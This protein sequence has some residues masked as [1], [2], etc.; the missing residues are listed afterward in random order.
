MHQSLLSQI[1]EFLAETGM[2]AYRFGIRA[3][4]NGRLVERLKD[5]RRIWPD[6]EAKVRSFIR[7]ERAKRA[8]AKR[9]A[10]A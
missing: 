3:A 6:T 4:K 1:D 8:S 9:G 2:S 10:A 5:Q 7:S